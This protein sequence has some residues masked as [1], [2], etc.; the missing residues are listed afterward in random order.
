M[1]KLI[2]AFVVFFMAGAVLMVMIKSWNPDR[3]V[4]YGIGGGFII[5]CCIAGFLYHYVRHLDK[6]HHDHPTVLMFATH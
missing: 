4:D 3:N 6:Y 5:N 1:R 2:F